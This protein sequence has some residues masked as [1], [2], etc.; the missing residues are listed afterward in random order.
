[1]TTSAITQQPKA[2]NFQSHLPHKSLQIKHVDLDM[3]SYI[4]DNLCS[5]HVIRM[6]Y[7]NLPTIT[8]INCT[9]PPMLT[10]KVR[11]FI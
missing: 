1:M 6:D 10:K 7:K 3:D 5:H 9:F 11:R 2:N 4:F 8:M